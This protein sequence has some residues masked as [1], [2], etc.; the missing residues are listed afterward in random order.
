M[1]NFCNA[2]RYRMSFKFDN[3]SADGLQSRRA[4]NKDYSKWNKESMAS[5][6]AK[7]L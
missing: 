2:D 7:G 5:K 3:L 4:G 6:R 1:S